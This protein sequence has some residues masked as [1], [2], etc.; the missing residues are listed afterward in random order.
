MRTGV[1]N[2]AVSPSVAVTP[3]AGVPF[4]FRSEAC[5]VDSRMLSLKSTVI[6]DGTVSYDVVPSAGVVPV[7]WNG[8]WYR[9]APFDRQNYSPWLAGAAVAADVTST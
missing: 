6:C 3:M 1:L 4:T 7:T 2:A 9:V 5:S 8:G